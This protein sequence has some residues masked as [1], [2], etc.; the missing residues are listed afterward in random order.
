M[1][2]DSYLELPEGKLY[3][4]LDAQD[5]PSAATKPKPALFFI[6]AGVADLHLWD[7]QV[8][9]F[10]A[11]G[12]NTIRYDIFGHG[13]S[14][15]N[16]AFLTQEPR[17]PI[18]HHDHVARILHQVKG[19]LS[20]QHNGWNGKIVII[21]LSRGGAQTVDVGLAYPDLVQGLVVVAGGLSG[22]DYKE[23]PR[24]VQV[25]AQESKLQQARDIE[26]LAKFNAMYWGD[27]PLQKEGRAPARVREKLYSW[28]LDLAGRECDKTGGFAIRDEPLTPLAATRLSELNV[29]VAVGL[30]RFDE[31]CVNSAMKFL[32]EHVQGGSVQ[33]FD[34]AH[35]VNLECPQEFN[36]WIETWLEKRV[37]G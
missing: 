20:Q 28:G 19:Y 5:A 8:S 4:E 16:D 29:P 10:H 18:Q 25:L 1:T 14:L 2:Q 30:G 36:S 3:W 13:K 9:Y 37:A 17:P 15:P 23:D 32:G 27:G 31:S 12:W 6:H 11:K 26:G 7:E 21:G 35:M 34:A 24:E 33:E 22:F